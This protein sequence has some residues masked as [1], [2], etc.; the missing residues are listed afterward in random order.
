MD[1]DDNWHIEIYIGD[2]Y[3]LVTWI[4]CEQWNEC[5]SNV[6]VGIKAVAIKLEKWLL[7]KCD[8][9]MESNVDQIAAKRD[10]SESKHSFS[11]S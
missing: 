11:I 10:T 6:D 7:Y 1:I 2:D 8:L 4:K 5:W 9:N 3:S